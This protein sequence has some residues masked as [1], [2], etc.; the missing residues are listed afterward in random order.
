[1]SLKSIFSPA[2]LTLMAVGFL[3]GCVEREVRLPGT[4]LDPRAVGSPD[5]P[6]V[7]EPAVTTTALS[8]PGVRANSEWTHRGSGPTHYSGHVSLGGS[9]QPL[10]TAPIGQ[11]S[12][13]RH[14][15]SADPIV[16][17]G[18]IFT[19]DSHATVT[20]TALSG[21]RAWSRD[22]TPAG[23][24][25]NSGSG[26]GV[27]YGGGRVFVSTGYGELLGLDAASGQIVWRQRVGVP[28]GG[29]PTVQNGVVYV[30]NRSA[31]GFAV[32][33][34]DGKL[35]WQVAGIPQPT[36]VTGVAAPAVDGDLVIF[37]FS[38]GQLLAV[39]RETGIERWSAQVAGNRP[40]RA[41]AYIRDMT[42]EPV[43][44][45]NRVYAGTSS[46]RMVAVDRD[47][48][49]QIWTAREG[50]A[51]P[52][53]PVGNA[54]FAV[55][56]QN[57]LV[58]LDAETGGLVWARNL[59]WYQE[60]NVKRQDRIYAQYGP[61]LASGRLLVASA[62]GV[63]RVFDPSSGAV[64]GQVAIPGGAA[65]APVVAGGTLYVA[66]RDGNLYAYR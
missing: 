6:A 41:V 66:G 43:I 33:A 60:S 36:G 64:I 58:R 53:L 46:G 30:T 2:C 65:T 49:V 16:A 24:N 61:I 27:A 37:P 29:A 31:T 13:K 1:M 63:I 9:L 22:L 5:G 52:V 39:D 20:A 44:A 48:G 14:R 35:L 56:D 18:R 25:P 57:Q 51:S 55:N 54:V 45:G 19:L 7:V 4:R 62:D 47:T 17:G 50:A 26:G 32:R 28:V 21:G 10:F 8:L 59:P 23:E 12:G 42:G 38:S 3:A 40:G 15:I 34:S 11:P